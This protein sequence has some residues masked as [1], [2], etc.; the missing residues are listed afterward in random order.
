MK[1]K[2]SAMNSQ[3]CHAGSQEGS[4]N[5]NNNVL[6]INPSLEYSEMDRE[7]SQTK[8]RPNIVRHLF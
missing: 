6:G 8:Y 2:I 1:W 5:N 7:K 3:T 4:G